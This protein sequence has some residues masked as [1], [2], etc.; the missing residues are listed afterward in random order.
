MAINTCWVRDPAQQL[1]T[2]LEARLD[3]YIA[4]IDDY[5]I[6]RRLKEEYGVDEQQQFHHYIPSPR[7]GLATTSNKFLRTGCSV[8]LI[9]P[10]LYGTKG[11]ARSSSGSYVDTGVAKA[12]EEPT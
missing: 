6:W 8:E 10:H 12:P 1:F 3:S 9:V 7:R 11:I 4:I 2:A 5:V